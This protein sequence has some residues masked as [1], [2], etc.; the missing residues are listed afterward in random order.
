MKKLL[1]VIGLLLLLAL[2]GYGALRVRASWRATA[3]G[4]FR[5]QPVSRGDIQVVVNS[6]GTVQPVQSVQVGS[7]VSG[8]IQ[9]VCVD[10]NAQV[11]TGD[12]LA[13]VD[14][15]MYK[16]AVA[17][18][19]ANL[20]H[21][22]ADVER[23]QA[24][25]EQAT[26]NE[27]RAIK[28]KETHSIAESDFDQMLAERRSLAAQVKLAEAAVSQAQ[29]NLT[30]S[31]TNLEFTTIRA[32][33]DGVVIDRKVDPGQT[34]ASQFQTPVMFVVAPDLTKK[35]Y[36]YASVDEADIGQIRKAEKAG[37]PVRFTVDAYPDDTFEGRINQTR[38]N[39]TTVQNVVTYTVVV[40]APNGELKLLPGMT[41]NLTFQIEKHASVLRVPNAAL[42]F[43]P[44]ADQVVPRDRKI[45]ENLTNEPSGP[46]HEGDESPGT[47]HRSHT[48]RYVWVP[49]A[50]LLK[51]VAVVTGASDTGYAE[52]ISG[53]LDDGQEL[54]TGTKADAAES[55]P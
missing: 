10:F 4:N 9:K 15:R 33:V 55:R 53:Q 18:D 16:A 31:R 6:S 42:R 14:P 43:R 46:P 24:L 13:E 34:V 52:L 1:I 27:Q 17:R 11:H 21:A 8:P 41:A 19:E 40:E 32:P 44:R 36:V 48:R 49:D 37:E 29:A 22:Q 39:P 38:L 47:A 3:D 26:R 5:T 51:A 50:A 2:A 35:I 23:V 7:F 12:V 30:S 28:L 25:L 54:A 20:A 45:L